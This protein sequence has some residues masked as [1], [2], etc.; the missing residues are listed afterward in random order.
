MAYLHLGAE[1]DQAVHAYTNGEV[2]QDAP[3]HLEA[4]VA[5][6]I[7]QVWRERKVIN[8]VADDNRDQIFEPPAGRGTQVLSRHGVAALSFLDGRK[9]R[10]AARGKGT[11]PRI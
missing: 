2:D 1:A 10:Q 3:I 9:E 7:R 5:Q 11:R 6:E 8:G 4:I